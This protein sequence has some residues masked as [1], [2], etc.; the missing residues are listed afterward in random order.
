MA[1]VTLLTRDGR[2]LSAL[3]GGP[4]RQNNDDLCVSSPSSPTQD[5]RHSMIDLSFCPNRTTQS[6]DAKFSVFSKDAENENSCTINNPLDSDR[7]LCKNALVYAL[8]C[9]PAHLPWALTYMTDLLMQPTPPNHIKPCEIG[10]GLL[11][12]F[13][14]SRLQTKPIAPKARLVMKR[15]GSTSSRSNDARALLPSSHFGHVFKF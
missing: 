3:C 6:R 2:D 10:T 4:L 11:Q 14:L 15:G 1:Q 8:L 9:T 7:A 5:W 13:R 12:H